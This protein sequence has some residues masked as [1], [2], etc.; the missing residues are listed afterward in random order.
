VERET[1]RQGACVFSTTPERTPRSEICCTGGGIRTWSLILALS[2]PCDSVCVMGCCTSR[3]V[4]GLWVHDP[5]DF[6][7]RPPHGCCT[8]E[9]RFGLLWC[10][11]REAGRQ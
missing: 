7:A 8:E 11:V 2:C 4:H 10:G 9:R 3:R 1:S 5:T 6:A